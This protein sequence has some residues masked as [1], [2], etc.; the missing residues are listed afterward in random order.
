MSMLAS[1]L[2]LAMTGAGLGGPVNVSNPTTLVDPANL[3]LAIFATAT[4][5]EPAV[6]ALGSDTLVRVDPGTRVVI[7]LHEGTVVVRGWDRDAVEV[8]GGGEDEETRVRVSRSSG[9]LTLHAGGRWGEPVDGDLIVNVPASSPLKVHAP[10]ADV[11]IE[12]VRRGVTVETVEGDIRLAGGSE[13]VTLHTVEGDIEVRDASGRIE[14]HSMDGDT[15]LAGV[16]GDISVNTVDGDVR[17]EGVASSNVK[18]QTVD[19]DILFAG[20]LRPSGVY[21]LST[22]DGDLYVAVPENAGAVVS[23]A[24]WAG[25]FGASF[26]IAWEGRRDGKRMEFTI[27]HGGARL[28][29]QSFDGE[30]RLIRPGQRIPEDR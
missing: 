28:E 3:G 15:R 1:I 11:Q 18:A 8:V 30:I 10:F 27:G 26:P 2:A 7:Q 20:E 24:T 4:P 19:G 14:L 6:E 5:S 23:I 21:R 16:S 25:E 9:T 22:H 13:V 12:G 29:L 17:L